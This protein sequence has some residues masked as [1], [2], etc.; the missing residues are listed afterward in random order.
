VEFAIAVFKRASRL[1]QDVSVAVEN[2]NEILADK[3]VAPTARGHEVSRLRDVGYLVN[4]LNAQADGAIA[5]RNG[6]GR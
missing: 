3:A 2:A 4:K 6:C 1:V 5:R